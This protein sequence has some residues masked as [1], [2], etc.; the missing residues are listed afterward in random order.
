MRQ[1]VDVLTLSATPIPR[2]LHMSLS[3]IRD[4]S[5]IETPPENRL[6]V[7]TYVGEFS[8]KLV[9]DAILREIERDGQV[10]FV[11]NR[12]QSIGMVAEKLR[13]LVP[14]VRIA[15]AHGQMDEEQLEKVMADFQTGK[16]DVLL[17]T[18]IIESGLD[19]PNVN[20]LIV[21]AADK[22]GL[23]QLYQLRGR[24]GRGANTAY[25]YFM[26]D[27]GKDIT[28][29]A[30]ERLKTIA[31]AAELGAGF[32]IAMKD[33]EIRGAGSLLGV[34]QSGHIAA[35]GFNYYCQ[36]LSEA[37]A[38]L[39]AGRTGVSAMHA[40]EKP[41]L[42]VDLHL[43]AFIPED[44][45]EDMRTRFNFYQ[46]LAR[47][48]TSVNVNDVAREMLD[49]F[50]DLP[51]EVSNLLYAVSVRQ[52]AS[53]KGIESVLKKG[54]QITITF[55]ESADTDKIFALLTRRGAAR[56]GNRRLYMDLI[57]VRVDWKKELR[58]V[59]EL[60]PVLHN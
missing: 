55:N 1:T 22:M 19:L 17:T 15:I 14:E 9:R 20:T 52:L 7:V 40:V 21:N 18:T 27:S 37:V 35:V 42:T 46:R 36:L 28:D 54:D 26:F 47:M 29:Q 56:P 8:G 3:G 43:P 59:L 58:E 30:R 48:D 49:R 12:V 23:T 57:K 4:M 60:M 32:V 44:Y 45:I 5:I 39:K 10:F 41:V 6:P 25:A 38:E 13:E 11:H 31:S 34:E 53:N 2:T 51:Q 50:G 16:I 33:M 24:V